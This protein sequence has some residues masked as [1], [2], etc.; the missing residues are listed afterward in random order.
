MS[1]P[2]GMET[3][4]AADGHVLEGFVARPAGPAKGGIVILQEI[5]GVTDQLK[6]VA[7]GYAAYGYA[8]VVPAL[9]DR[10]APGTVVPFDTPE[11]GRE[12]ALG[13]APDKVALDVAA[14]MAAVDTGVGVALVGFCWGGG[15]AFRLA[16]RLNPACAVGY[17]ATAMAKH[18]ESCP[19]GPNGPVMF[20]FGDADDHTPPD[21]IAAIR[22]QVPGAVI[23]T[24]GAGHAFAN[25]HRQTHVPDAARLARERTLAFLAQHL[26]R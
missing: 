17:Y 16:C 19:D 20:H 12:M 15:Q 14:A 13:L 1:N 11:P 18:L 23:H 21:V 25:D 7:R 24:Y 22:A 10:A 9:F 3:L 8:A 4:T 26:G 6:G 2:E 5:F